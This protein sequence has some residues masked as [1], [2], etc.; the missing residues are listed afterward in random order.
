MFLGTERGVAYS[1]DAGSTF[2]PLRLNLPTVPVHDLVVKNNDLVVGTHGRSIWILDDLTPVREGASALA[3]QPLH[4]FPAQDAVRYRY[5]RGARGGSGTMEN[6]PAGAVIHYHLAAPPKEP[7][8][9]EVRDARGDLV[10]TLS[11]KADPDAAAADEAL[12]AFLRSRRT[13]LTTEVGVNRVV[14]DLT[15]QGPTPIKGAVARL[16]PLSGPMVNPGDYV[17]RLTAD[18]KT[19]TANLAVRPDPRVQVSPA[20]LDEQLKFALG[21]RDD[22][23]RVSRTVQ[24]VR[25]LRQQL[26]AR[27]DVWKDQASARDLLKLSQDLVGKLDTLEGRLHNAKFEIPNDVI[28]QR[29]GAKLYPQ[30]G[31]LLGSVNGGDGAPTQGMREVYAEHKK[32][33][34]QIESELNGLIGGEL[35]RLNRMAKDLDLLNVLVPESAAETGRP[36]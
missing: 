32:E 3:G 9:L 23:S 29:G 20:D 4:L 26:A 30:L 14:W 6:P 28:M 25:S 1:A 34:E 19:V 24:R 15:H 8:T 7:L 11:S 17:L 31:A 2:Q 18:G 10:A 35:P 36:R 16:G 5:G 12:P 33:L 13:Q 21:V 22:I 27:N